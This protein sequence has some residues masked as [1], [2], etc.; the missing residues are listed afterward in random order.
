MVDWDSWYDLEWKT[1]DGINT[2]VFSYNTNLKIM[3]FLYS[4]S[5]VLCDALY[6]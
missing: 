3:V 2:K 1:I 6:K 5:S 4:L